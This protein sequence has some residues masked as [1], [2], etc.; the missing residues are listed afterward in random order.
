MNPGGK[1]NIHHY[2]K[3]LDRFGFT[4]STINSQK[5][6]QYKI[7]RCLIFKNCSIL[8]M[9]A[10]TSIIWNLVLEKK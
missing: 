3:I 8:D 1:K 4:A 7:I 6:I 9:E 2:G 5:P 10:I